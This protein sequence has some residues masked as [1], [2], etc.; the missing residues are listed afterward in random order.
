MA[1]IYVLSDQPRLPYPQD[2]DA[3][4]VS[5]AG[6]LTVYAVL[7][8][9]LWWALGVGHVTRSRRAILAVGLATLYGFFD[10]WHQSFVPGRTPDGW[11]I[12]T[13]L[14]GATCAI[15]LVT[16]LERRGVFR[17]RS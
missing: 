11:D 16:W 14:T 4:F 6:H 3:T 15:L 2:L 1:V 13:D 17:E 9:L 7:A 8:V 12:V 10:E 5:I